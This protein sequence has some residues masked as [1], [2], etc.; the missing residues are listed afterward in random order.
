MQLGLH[1]GH[2]IDHA[3][4]RRNI[5]GVHHRGGCDLEVDRHVHGCCHL[6]DCRDAIVRIEEQPFPVE[7]Y[8][9][10]RDRL[11]LFRHRAFRIDAV[12]RP[13]GIELVCAH[14]GDR[15]ERDDD[16]QRR[17]PDDDF[18]TGGMVPFRII[19]GGS[20]RLA[21]APGEEQRQEND[22]YDNQQHQDRRN[23]DQIPLLR[24]NIAGWRHH[25]HVA[26]RECRE[27]Q[28]GYH[29]SSG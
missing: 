5:K 6:V 28:D 11:H 14:P 8:D 3:G 16:R 7:S 18:K 9:L 4:E 22:G 23:D 2:G 12:E 27:Q 26:S 24:G 1:A 21:I 13:V 19:F 10:D 29:R 17:R 20:V 25:N 15:P